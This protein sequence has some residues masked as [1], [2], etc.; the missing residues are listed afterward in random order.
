MELIEH[1]T[2]RKCETTEVF[3]A[4][5]TALLFRHDPVQIGYETNCEE[6][7]PEALSICARLN[8]CSGSNDVCRVVYE[9]L[10]RSFGPEAV[11]SLQEYK[12]LAAETW[13]LWHRLGA[14]V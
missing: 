6:Y 5:L 7:A 4:E 11:G 9:E 13:A 10:V 12:E 3:S 1:T 2:V 14:F 8:T